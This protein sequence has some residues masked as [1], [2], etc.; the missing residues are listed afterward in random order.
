MPKTHCVAFSVLAG[1]GP[2]PDDFCL[3]DRGFVLGSALSQHRD[4]GVLFFREHASFWG[5]TLRLHFGVFS[6][7]LRTEWEFEYLSR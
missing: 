6:N 2:V 5:K 1:P 3:D 4:R 7:S